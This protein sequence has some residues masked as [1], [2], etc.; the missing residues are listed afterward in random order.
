MLD[1][2][3]KS[4]HADAETLD[5]LS[6]AEQVSGRP[7]RAIAALEQATALA[8][9]DPKL[10]TRLAAVRLG[11]GDPTG[12]ATDLQQSLDLSPDQSGT[13][14][15]LVVAAL[16][17][18]DLDRA[19]AALEKLGASKNANP[20]VVGTLT[21]LVKLAA[22]DLAGARASFEEVVRKNPD[23]VPGRLNL[24]RVLAADGKPEEAEK[25]LA[26]ILEKQ[27]ANAA[28]LSGQVG[29]LLAQKKNDEALA[30]VA[31]ARA[32]APADVGILI[33]QADLQGRL[34]DPK[35]AL[36]T[37][38]QLPKDQA[39]TQAA[40]AARVRAQLGGKDETAAIATLRDILSRT[41]ADLAAR[42]QLLSLLVQAKDFEGARA[43]IREG[44][45]AGPGNAG[46]LSAAVA[47]E[48]Q[49]GGTEAAL[50]TA[51]RLG[52]DPKNGVVG[53]MLRGD[54]LLTNKR[55][56][57]AAAAYA[58]EA[59][60][61]P[62]AALTLR[63]YAALQGAGK[64]A[65]AE[66]DLRQWM[67]NNPEDV[68]VGL[69]LS[70]IDLSAGRTDPAR[71]VLEMVV[72]KRPNTAAALNNLAYI[73]QQTGDKRARPLAQK[74]YLLAPTPR[75]PTP[76][77]GLW[78]VR[79]RRPRPCPCSSSRRRPSR[80]IRRSPTTTPPRSRPPATRQVPRPSSSPSSKAPRI[81][82]RSRPPGNSTTACRNSPPTVVGW[83]SAHRK[84]PGWQLP[85]HPGFGH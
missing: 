35:A 39:A 59:K 74:A 65:E 58:T 10:L 4:G 45:E 23:S 5:L 40:L 31:K 13:G 19:R 36:T 61:A 69:V 29:V 12:A 66:A 11:A 51:D 6:R 60:T 70:S 14:E 57:E 72:A 44:L 76:S 55:F 32:A 64:Q 63:R 68:D 16:A 73:Y 82:A 56:D 80:M 3:V 38:D 27:P 48:Q 18:G 84:H 67:V 49:A 50:V 53:R 22:L 2:A 41:P 15:A 37:L 9:N 75:A 20:E 42:G 17:A 77:A 83:A 46:L 78:S 34:G 54:V 30:L 1:R 26:P 71:K 81:S 62:S 33:G 8:P 24:A 28:A 47:V 79:A 21:G 7:D 85:R 52:R 25:Q 43:A